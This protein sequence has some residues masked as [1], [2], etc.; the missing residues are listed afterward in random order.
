[1]P[2]RTADTTMS[3][4][5]STSFRPLVHLERVPNSVENS[6][7]RISQGLAIQR[8]HGRMRFT[9]PPWAFV[10]GECQRI[11][12][13]LCS[14]RWGLPLPLPFA[15]WQQAAGAAGGVAPAPLRPGPRQDAVSVQR[16][17]CPSR[18]M[19]GRKGIILPPGLEPGIAESESAVISSLTTGA[20][21]VMSVASKS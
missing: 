6:W 15:Q 16:Q 9:R 13:R 4:A 12:L 7:R 1:M 18:D 11:H 21:D 5:E 10:Q 20:R 2:L 14:I 3:D 8:Y 17:E 19:M